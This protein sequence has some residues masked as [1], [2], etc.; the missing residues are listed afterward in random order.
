MTSNK[1]TFGRILVAVKHWYVL[2]IGI[3]VAGLIILWVS[4]NPQIFHTEQPSA[5]VEPTPL[6][7]PAYRNYSSSDLAFITFDFVSNFMAFAV[8]MGVLIGLVVVFSWFRSTF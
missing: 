1:K 3:L 6:P 5:T 2:V 8:I 4:E 7:A